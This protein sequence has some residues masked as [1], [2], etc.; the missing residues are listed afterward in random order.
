VDANEQQAELVSI[1]AEI[2]RLL[3]RRASVA[4]R[5]PAGA[6]RPETWY[7][8]DLDARTIE[9]AASTSDGPLP[10]ASIEAI[11]REILSAV[12]ALQ[13]P[14][15]VG[16]L[17]PIGTFSYDAA[18]RQFGHGAVLTA[19]RTIG[20]IFVEAQR[21]AVDYG[22]VP[23]ENSTEGA[24]TPALDRL[25]ETDLQISAALELPVRHYLLSHGQLSQITKVYSHPQALAQCRRWLA[26]NLP[27]AT[28][29]E[30][31]STAAAA[32]Q[33]TSPD[34][35]AISTE[36]AAELYDLPI[37][38]SRIEDVASNVTRF[39]VIGPHMSSRSGRDRTAIVFSVEDRTGA[40][41]TALKWLAENGVNMTRIESRPSRRRLWEYVFFVELDGHPDDEPVD[42]AIA[43]LKQ[44]SAFVRVLGAWPV[45]PERGGER[46]GT[47]VA[48]S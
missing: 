41:Y 27:A 43:G 28:T 4:L 19:C 24:V 16:Y 6:E 5:S 20:D 29:V 38:A 32:Q 12:R 7:R 2:V 15:R 44:S 1:D 45:Q 26:D 3:H 11:Y 33:A 36:S 17:G 47:L 31:S 40:L 34:T 9:R 22:V 30:A 23:V 25:V 42:R 13:R 21:Q 14:P 48:A 39:F 8:P 10:R 37:I 35:A 18:I 46:R